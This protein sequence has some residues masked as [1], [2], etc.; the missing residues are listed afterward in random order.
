MTSVCLSLEVL[1][2]NQPSASLAL[3]VYILRTAAYSTRSIPQATP[4]DPLL[5]ELTL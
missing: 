5:G 2:G 4:S 3:S 1:C